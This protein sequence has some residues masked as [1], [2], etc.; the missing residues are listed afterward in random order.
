MEIWSK[1]TED[2]D[3]NVGSLSLIKKGISEGKVRD[4]SKSEENWHTESSF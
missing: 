4:K 2:G 3:D 1:S